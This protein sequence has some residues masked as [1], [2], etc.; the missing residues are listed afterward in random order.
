M[1]APSPPPPLP[2]TA[3]LPYPAVLVGTVAFSSALYTWHVAPGLIAT[4]SFLLAL[5]LTVATER[6]FPED[7]AVRVD[8]EDAVWLAVTG[9]VQGVWQ[10]A[11][12]ALESAVAP[13]LIAW[14]R[15]SWGVHSAPLAAQIALSLT[16]SELLKYGLHRL[17]HERAGLWR[18]HA[19]HH[20]P[21]KV[22]AINGA[23]M[24]PVNLVWNLASDALV[25][26]ALGLDLRAAVLLAALRN[27]V[28]AMQHANASLRLDGWNW[29]FSTPDLHRWHHDADGAARTNYGSTLM[30]WDVVFGTR[31]LP[32][33][34]PAR[35][36]LA[37]GATHP[38]GLGAQLAWPWSRDARVV[39]QAP[40]S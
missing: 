23:R 30:V 15:P 19:E 9:G 3:A 1:S 8:P 5:G 25:P 31:R 4:F 37:E 17:S 24:H 22:Y 11:F 18:F 33:G 32:P 20:C 27:A 29:L 21:P 28:A 16:L 39:P 26:L 7:P 34:R 35:Y 38:K 36:G 2:W 14:G 13:M 40:P 12:V 10:L 6:I